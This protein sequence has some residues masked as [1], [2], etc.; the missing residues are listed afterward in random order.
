[1]K[2]IAALPAENARERKKRIGTIGSAAAQLPGDE[3]RR[4][5]RAPA[6]SAPMISTLSQPT[7]VAAHQAPD[8]PEGAAR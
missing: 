3:R 5:A 8:E 7:G 1:M 6:T 4:P 2:K